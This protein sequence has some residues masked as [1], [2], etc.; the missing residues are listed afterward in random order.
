MIKIN[1]TMKHGKILLLFLILMGL[2]YSCV[3]TKQL[4]SANTD[5]PANFNGLPVDT[6][7]S[8]QLKWSHFFEDEHLVALID[9]ALA[10]NQELRIMMQQIDVAQNEVKARKGEYLPF[11]NYG[12]G[13][14]VE[15]VGEYTRN[16]A[17]EKNLDI[18]EGEEFPEPLTDYSAGLF[19][20]WELDVWKKLRNSKKAATLEYLS[21][22]EGKNFMVTRL[23]AEIAQS[24]YEL[25]ALDNQLAIIEQNLE[26]QGN[27]LTMVRLQKQAARATELAVKRFE[28]EVAKNKSHKFEVQ[29]EIVEMENKLNFLVGRQPQ[30]IARNSDDFT[31]T[32][33]N[34]IDA[35]IPSQLLLNRP[36]I[37]QAEFELEAAKLNIKVARANFY[38]SIT[39]KAGVGLQAFKPKYL[40][41]T[42]ESLIYSAVGDIVGP[43]INRNAIKADY[44]TANSKQI[45]AV[46]EYEKAVLGGYIEV[47]SMLSKIENLKQRYMLKEDQ[48]ESLT[49]SID[50]S[51]RL[52]QSARI[53]YTEV[54]FTQRE[55][56]ESRMELVETKKEQ[57][58]ARVQM[59]Q[60]LGGGWF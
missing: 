51:T 42:P 24:Y 28:A 25:I 33:I 46:Y 45:Q 55:A 15:K 40:T 48:V 56:L 1:N 29:Q 49:A 47:V 38:P 12:A 18:R 11:I 60:A 6:L 3:P 13:A 36:D 27:A 19:A 16:G 54:L 37:R 2:F 50:L 57:L 41:H 52:F 26:L 32:V 14:E 53:E 59:Y 43:L 4:K 10:N 20:T 9:T 23:I 44:N 30:H 7:N 35:G 34:T 21:T 8:A 58:M 31:A 17:V 5:L 22:I 39:L